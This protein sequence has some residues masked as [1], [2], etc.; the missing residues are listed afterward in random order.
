MKLVVTDAAEA[1]LE[2]I[3]DYIAADSP[4]RAVTFVA[5]MRAACERL[6][7]APLAAPLLS[8]HP[9]S[10]IRRRRHGSYLIFY[11]LTQDAVVVPRTLHGAR[12]H[13]TILFPEDDET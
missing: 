4:R 8:W 10:G 5:E 3:G 9:E 13:M 1:D 7:H 12:D 2:A 11:R 6:L